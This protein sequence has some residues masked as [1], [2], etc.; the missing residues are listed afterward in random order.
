MCRESWVFVAQLSK[1]FYYFNDRKCFCSS[2]SIKCNVLKRYFYIGNLKNIRK[3]S[4][5]YQ[6]NSTFKSYWFIK[7][8][9]AKYLKKTRMCCFPLISSNMF[10][11]IYLTFCY[12][13]IPEGDNS[14]LFSL[15]NSHSRLIAVTILG[16]NVWTNFMFSWVLVALQLYVLVSSVN[17]EMNKRKCLGYKYFLKS[18]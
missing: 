1:L 11:S 18:I 8:L 9:N 6:T 5:I 2:I 12:R 3:Y 7:Y 4:V 13:S 15:T 16:M 14:Y 17:A 10:I